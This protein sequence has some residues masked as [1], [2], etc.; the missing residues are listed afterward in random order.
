MKYYFETQND[1]ICYNLQGIKAIMQCEGEEEMEVYEAKN[2]EALGMFW[3]SYHQSIGDKEIDTCG[4]SCNAY[5][6]RN[7]RSGCCSH[8]STKFYTPSNKKVTIRL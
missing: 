6:P 5:K 3:C 2:Q 8:Y 4:K 1:E 7:K